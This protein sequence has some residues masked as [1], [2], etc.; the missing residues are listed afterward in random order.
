MARITGVAVLLV[1]LCAGAWSLRLEP[2]PFWIPGSDASYNVTGTIRLPYAEIVEPFTVLYDGP[3]GRGRVDYYN[4]IQRVISKVKTPELPYGVTLKIIPFSTQKVLNKISCFSANGSQEMPT[5]LTVIFPD[6]TDFKYVGKG[7]VRGL[8]CKMYQKVVTVGKKKSTYTM[9]VTDDAASLPVRYE[10][11]GYDSLLGSH[12]DKY[13]VDY[14]EFH[15]HVTFSDADFEVPPSMKCGPY[16]GPGMKAKKILLDPIREFIH[17]QEDHMHE[18]FEIF[19]KVHGKTYDDAEHESRKHIFRQNLRYISSKNRAGL[20]YTLAVNHMA[21][22]TESEMKV[23]RGFRYSHGPRGGKTFSMLQIPRND[24]PDQ[25]DWRLQGAVTPVKDQAICGSC[26][27]FGTTGTIEGA[28]FLKTGNL[29]RLSQQELVDCA[30]GFGNNGCDGG[31]DF[32]SYGYMLANG[33]LT[34]EEQYGQYLAIDSFCKKNSVTPVVQITNYT[35]LPQGDLNALKVALFNY[36]PISV[37]IDASHKSF[38]FYSDGVYYDPACKSDPDS[39]DHA[40]LAVGYGVMDNQAYWLVKNSWSTHWGNDGY[41][42]MS[43][44]NNN[45]GVATDATYVDIK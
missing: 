14:L 28:N 23:M 21:D 13:Y 41:V 3:N 12:Y 34:S 17:H 25:W 40:V 44:K 18:E 43:Q 32:R 22:R 1:S 45:C 27:S 8:P 11:M 10:M 16:P 38:G 9:A 20:S 4:G 37:A 30:W 31:E 2:K 26:W 5:E 29:V 33:G 7:A 42:L 35:T 15:D 24:V 6:T 19:K 36:G 39:L